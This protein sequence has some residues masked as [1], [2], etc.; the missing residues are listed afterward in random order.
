MLTG[1]S[2]CPLVVVG[3]ALADERV[4]VGE[5]GGGVGD[6]VALEVVVRGGVNGVVSREFLV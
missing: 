4:L 2:I 6:G 5:N 1:Q 3:D